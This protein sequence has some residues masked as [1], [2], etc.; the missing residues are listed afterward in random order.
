MLKSVVRKHLFLPGETWPELRARLK[1]FGEE[2]LNR[3]LTRGRLAIFGNRRGDTIARAVKSF[4]VRRLRD[5]NGR[6]VGGKLLYH[7]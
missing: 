2:K 6:V 7:P 4:S 1:I 3:P 5:E